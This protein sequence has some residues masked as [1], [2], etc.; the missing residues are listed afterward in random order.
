[1]NK[2]TED[3]DVPPYLF[4][5]LNILFGIIFLYILYKVYKHLKNK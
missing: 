1:M 3:Y 2:Y 4:Q 5:L